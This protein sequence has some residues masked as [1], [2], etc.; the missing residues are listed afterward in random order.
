M[1]DSLSF[2]HSFSTTGLHVLELRLDSNSEV[3]ELNDESIGIDNNRI[4]RMSL[5]LK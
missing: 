2:P 3:D 5:S 4:L 1:L